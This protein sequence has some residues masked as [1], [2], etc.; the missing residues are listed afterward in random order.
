MERAAQLLDQLDAQSLALEL[1]SERIDRMRAA[2]ARAI[3]DLDRHCG[4]G[5][6]AE[7]PPA[8]LMS[9]EAA[10]ACAVTREAACRVELRLLLARNQ[11]RWRRHHQQQLQQKQQF[12]Q[13][14]Q[15]NPSALPPQEPRTRTDALSVSYQKQKLQQQQQQQQQQA[16][17]QLPQSSV[18]SCVKTSA[19]SSEDPLVSTVIQNR[20]PA[21]V[22]EPAPPTE[23]TDLGQYMRASLTSSAMSS[24]PH[25]D[26]ELDNQD[27]EQDAEVEQRE[28]HYGDI[29]DLVDGGG[30]AA[31]SSTA[32]AAVA[33]AAGER[34]R[35]E[36]E[37]RDQESRLLRAQAALAAVREEASP[38]PAQSRQPRQQ[39]SNSYAAMGPAGHPRYRRAWCRLTAIGRGFLVRRLMQSDRVQEIVRAIRDT[40]EFAVSLVR[41]RQS[42]VPAAGA[43]VGSAAISDM[44]LQERVVKSL[45]ASLLELHDVFFS[46]PRRR[47]LGLIAATRQARIEALRKRASVAAS[48]ETTGSFSAPSASAAVASDAGSSPRQRRQL[49]LL[50]GS[51]GSVQPQQLQQTSVTKKMISA[52][53]R[54]RMLARQQ[55]QQQAPSNRPATAAVVRQP[56]AHPAQLLS[57]GRSAE[58]APA[59]RPKTAPNSVTNSKAG[60]HNSNSNNN[61]NN[62]NSNNNNNNNKHYS[63]GNS[64]GSA[65]AASQLSRRHQEQPP[66]NHQLAAAVKRHMALD[67]HRRVTRL[68]AGN[69]RSGSAV[70]DEAQSPTSDEIA[71]LTAMG[72]APVIYVK[73]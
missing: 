20:Q 16:A 29:G 55:Q 35:C 9:A 65:N 46:L 63:S 36:R 56:Q 69:G 28:K 4:S 62:N 50:A 60:S 72:P 25:D 58:S 22:T 8:P 14:Q 38:Q 37:L 44:A 17:N 24:L 15:Q 64:N 48:V 12:Q 52:A 33:A 11:Q 2:N 23:S 18:N 6:V 61:S 5:L 73:K 53:T 30:P 10:A 32:A 26:D 34:Q 67:G 3:G 27:D 7:L 54:K 71:D 31:A 21:T 39:H 19:S 40:A 43:I 42:A 41:Q 66:V 70:S 45:R 57:N 47:Q 1:L 59:S 51:G 49:E 68:L 13:Q